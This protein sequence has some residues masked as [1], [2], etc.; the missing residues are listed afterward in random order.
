MIAWLSG[1][2][3]ELE[4]DRMIVVVQDLGYELTCSKAACANL[5]P[6]DHVEVFV[7]PHATEHATE[8][9]GFHSRLEKTLF[10]K[11]LSVQ[12]VGPKVALSILS[13]FGMKETVRLITSGQD[14]AL[15]GAPGVGKK[16][17]QRLVME[18]RETLLPF[19]EQ[20]THSM[21][22][23]LPSGGAQAITVVERALS[24]LRNMGYRPAELTT[25]AGPLQEAA[26]QGAA[27]DVLIRLGLSLLRK[28]KP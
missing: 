10:L 15:T 28:E 5:R 23:V 1:T 13:G 7:H 27:A 17:A 20:F 26:G 2:V 16:L 25:V 11:L 9:F 3:L 8:W 14:K 6:G 19:R 4:D 21:E 22:I 24:G 12:G 18:L